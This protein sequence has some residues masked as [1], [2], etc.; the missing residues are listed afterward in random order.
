M[1]SKLTLGKLGHCLGI[2]KQLSCKKHFCVSIRLTRFTWHDFHM[3]I[4]CYQNSDRHFECVVFFLPPSSPIV[5]ALHRNFM[6]LHNHQD[7]VSGLLSCAV[8]VHKTSLLFRAI[9]TQCHRVQDM[10]HML[11]LPWCA[12]LRKFYSITVACG[13]I[14]DTSC[15]CIKFPRAQVETESFACFSNDNTR[16]VW[17]LLGQVVFNNSHLKRRSRNFLKTQH[18]SLNLFVFISLLGA[19]SSS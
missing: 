11:A 15:L 8:E 5:S 1:P 17:E 2:I 16:K 12:S 14:K 6:P 4:I 7:E 13:G 9:W 10:G 19:S 3:T 18:K